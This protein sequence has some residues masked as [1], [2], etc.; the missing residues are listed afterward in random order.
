MTMSNGKSDAG[1]P[2]S[3]DAMDA[4]ARD[5]GAP[6]DGD[7]MDAGARDAGRAANAGRALKGAVVKRHL[8]LTFDDGPQPVTSALTPI[9]KEVEARGVVAAFFVLGEQVATSRGAIVAIR[10]AGHTVGNHSWD[11]MPKKGGIA[12]YTDDEIYD[13]FANTHVEVKKAGINMEHWRV[14]RLKYSQRVEK[15]LMAPK[16]PRTQLYSKRHCDV[17]ADSGDSQGANDAMSMLRTIESNFVDSRISPLHLN[18]RREWRLLFHVK[19]TTALALKKVLDELQA[20][21]G[22]FVDFLQNS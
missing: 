18:G 13:E 14:P 8:Q 3:T 6:S 12:A 17:Q 11:H 9:L 7:A 20:R 19:P 1:A 4:G 10:D 5:A 21:G 2:S 16:P 22:T 15:I